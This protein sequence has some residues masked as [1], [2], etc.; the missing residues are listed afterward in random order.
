MDKLN[1]DNNLLGR[2]LAL[3]VI[4]GTV[5]WISS[6]TGLCPVSGPLKP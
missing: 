3:A 4:V 6:V 2:V 1:A 5:A